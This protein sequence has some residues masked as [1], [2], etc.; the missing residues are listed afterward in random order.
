[1][2]IQCED[3]G[4]AQRIQQLKDEQA[5]LRD[6]KKSISKEL[7]NASRRTTR[8]RAKARQLTDEDLVH[9]LMMRKERRDARSTNGC[10]SA[11]NVE[12]TTLSDAASAADDKK[13]DEHNP[14]GVEEGGQ[15]STAAEAADV[16]CADVDQPEGHAI[17]THVC[18]SLSDRSKSTQSPH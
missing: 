10:P 2:Q 12:L 17:S 15:S 13:G 4:L 8:L 9:V 7:R 1:M 5:A 6:H 18:Y 11:H 16:D 14:N 3:S